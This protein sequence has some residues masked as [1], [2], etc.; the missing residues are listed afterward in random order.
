MQHVLSLLSHC[1]R[2]DTVSRPTGFGRV[3]L[4]AV[5]LAVLW[6]HTLGQREVTESKS[7]LVDGK[8]LFLQKGVPTRKEEVAELYIKYTQQL[9]VEAYGD[10]A[11]NVKTYRANMTDL[12]PNG[13]PKLVLIRDLSCSTFSSMICWVWNVNPFDINAFE[14]VTVKITIN[15]PAGSSA[16]PMQA[17]LYRSSMAS[18]PPGNRA[19]MDL[20]AVDSVDF[21]VELSTF[22]LSAAV[23]N[24]KLQFYAMRS[25]GGYITASTFLRMYVRKGTEIATKE[26]TNFKAA[27]TIGFGTVVTLIP[28]DADFCWR[29]DC[30]FSV[31][32]DVEG[33]SFV[34]F[35]TEAF[36][37]KTVIPF[38][39]SLGLM[40]QLRENDDATYELS[41]P[42]QLAPTPG[43]EFQW[44]FYLSPVEGDA[45][46]SINADTLPVS[47]DGYYIH[48]NLNS[49]EDIILNSKQ[50]LAINKTGNKFYIYMNATKQ[51]TYMMRVTRV[52]ITDTPYLLPEQPVTSESVKGQITNYRMDPAVTIP[53]TLRLSVKIRVLSGNPNLYVKE[54][55]NSEST[56]VVTSEDV[57]Q[58]NAL[59]QN[60][61][62]FFRFSDNLV[63]DDSL[64]LAF[65]CI[66]D[67]DQFKSFSFAS[68]PVAS[69]LYTSKSCKFAVAV[70][71]EASSVS[72]LSR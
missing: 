42:S 21:Q 26:N 33:I 24:A 62:R 70:V 55:L 16:P 17:K 65:N 41:T 71:G 22:D 10:G 23:Q 38:S 63:G 3:G 8:E 32:L 34:N 57:Q 44:R 59:S 28:S 18:L 14:M 67:T 5:C 19:Y 12:E 6:P 68:D 72:Q 2:T 64:E 30:V 7:T 37:R 47:Y 31:H 56:C 58:A 60:K 48:S 1:D 36:D 15:G 20:Q 54:C 29:N 52:G 9:Y 61:S 51:S 35:V 66:P 49:A 53:E 43:Q 11:I 25:W 4:L 45:D 39:E 13:K 46:I 27:N 40:D 69:S 50:L